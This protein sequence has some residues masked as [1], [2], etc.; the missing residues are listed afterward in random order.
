MS[1]WPYIELILCAI[2]GG[3]LYV[4]ISILVLLQYSTLTYYHTF[5][6]PCTNAL[7]EC[8]HVIISYYMIV[9][10][11]LHLIK[12]RTYLTSWK[13]WHKL[14]LK[15]LAYNIMW[16]FKIDKLLE[17]L[18]FMYPSC[19]T[20]LLKLI[21]NSQMTFLNRPVLLINIV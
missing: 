4:Y 16:V 6:N 5:T 7:V 12:K 2:Q 21:Y 14:K 3:Y 10:Y 17:W 8:I 9:A 18:N 11:K 19:F 1:T 13:L 15:S 20:F